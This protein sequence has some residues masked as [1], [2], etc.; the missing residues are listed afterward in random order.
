MDVQMP[1]MDGLQATAEIRAWETP[2]GRRTPIIA[3][4]AHAMKGDRERCL[5][6]GMD[7]Y[8]AKPIRPRDLC[9]ALHTFFPDADV[10]AAL[11]APVAR[12]PAERLLDW[13]AILATVQGDRDLL[14][15]VCAACLTEMPELESQLDAALASASASEA[16][17]LAH[18]IKGNLRTFG[19][20]GRELAQ[21]VEDAARSGQL[22][23]AAQLF[24]SLRGDLH[25]FRQELAAIPDSPG[26]D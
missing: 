12:L 9:E 10:P 26:P 8:V 15:E 14:R 23:Q 6:A 16:A 24:Q 19:A 5:Q 2:R 7:G 13:N 22:E 18:T 4:T 20:P 17:R 3:M 11:A 21:Q 1:E 25:S